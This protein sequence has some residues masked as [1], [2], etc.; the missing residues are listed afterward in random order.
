M[1]HKGNGS[2][3]EADTVTSRFAPAQLSSK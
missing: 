2:V 1:A 3:T